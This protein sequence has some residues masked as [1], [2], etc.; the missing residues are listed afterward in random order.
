MT[1][2]LL[3]F[4]LCGLL[5]GEAAAQS[6]ADVA[7]A[8]AA[9]RKEVPVAGKVYTNADLRPDPFAPRPAPPA[10]PADPA[11]PADPGEASEPPAPEAAPAIE[12]P[13]RDQAYWQA[14]ISAARSALQRSRMFAE[15]LQSRINGLNADFVNRDDPAQRQQIADERDKALEELARVNEDIAAETRAVAE[16]EDEARREGVPPGWLRGPS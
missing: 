8:E 1:R 11:E 16:I 12:E 4:A 13:P 14:R 9:R 15:A 5:S 3:A 6:L 2:F 10:D 7:R